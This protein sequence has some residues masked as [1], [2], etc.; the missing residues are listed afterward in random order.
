MQAFDGL[1]L[2][3]PSDQS[4]AP[5]GLVNEGESAMTVGLKGIPHLS[6]TLRI[7]RDI[8]LL[9]Y[10]GGKLHIPCISTAEGLE[11]IATAKENDLDI[12]CSV[13]IHN[14]FFDDRE[15]LD[16]NTNAKVNPPLRTTKDV[17][18]LRKGLLD[19]VIDMVTT[20]H[21]P[22]DIEEKKIEFDHAAFGTIGL[23]SAYGALNEIFGISK[24]TEILQ[25]GSA[26]FKIEEPSWEVGTN[27][28][29]TMFDPDEK[30]TFENADII[31]SSKKFFVSGCSIDGKVYGV[32]NEG[33]VTLK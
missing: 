21:S 15:I 28:C 29:F 2:N 25:R 26:R 12:S 4:L 32:I 9:N 27:A 7:Q 3:F 20:D 23:E 31:S 11:I 30:Y 22:I 8:A 19:G 17:Q 24:T 16:F 1:I 13:A 10:T 6:E 33:V 14:L 18:A 5:K